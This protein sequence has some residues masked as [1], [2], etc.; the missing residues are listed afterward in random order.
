MDPV[1]FVVSSC[2]SVLCAYHSYIHIRRTRSSSISHTTYTVHVESE[3]AEG[4]VIIKQRVSM[5][6][7]HR[8][9]SHRTEKVFT[10][11]LS[12]YPTAAAAAVVVF[13]LAD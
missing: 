13:A 4:I 5:L 6:L 11:K 3:R 7:R 9:L 2:L 1:Q 10:E 8:Q 12:Y